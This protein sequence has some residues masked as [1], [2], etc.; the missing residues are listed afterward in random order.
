MQNPSNSA[1][2]EYASVGLQTGVTAA[3]AH[4]LVLLMYDGALEALARGKRHMESG[5]IAAKCN[6]L[7]MATNIIAEGLKTSLDVKA[8][9]EIAQNLSDLYDYMTNRLLLANRN[10]RPE[11]LVEVTELLRQLSDAWRQIGKPQ[12]QSA[13][14]AP[15]PPASATYKPSAASAQTRSAPVPPAQATYKPSPA[16]ARANQTRAGAAQKQ[17]GPN[18]TPNTAAAPAATAPAA[19]MQ[20]SST[21][22]TAV[23][24][25][26]SASVAPAPAVNPDM[27]DARQNQANRVARYYGVS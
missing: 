7:A 19:T 1:L 6:A 11:I 25:Q 22:T 3:D 5:E 4:G 15:A 18:A 26:K 17:T 2:K 21:R 10:N 20:Q 27:G 14:D 23:S 12:P 16:S 9:G 13:G 8:G 24:T